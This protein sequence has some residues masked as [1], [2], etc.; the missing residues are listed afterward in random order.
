[1]YNL[2]NHPLKGAICKNK[3]A[4]EHC[5]NYVANALLKLIK[6]PYLI[7]SVMDDQVVFLLCVHNLHVDIYFILVDL[8]QHC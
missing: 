1:M 7:C 8:I 5:I 6:L 4:A 3:P 2:E